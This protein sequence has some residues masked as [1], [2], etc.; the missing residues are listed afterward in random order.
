MMLYRVLQGGHISIGAKPADD[1]DC[2]VC[3]I[4]VMPER[5]TL[6]YIGNMYLYERNGDGAK[7]IAQGDTGM[8]VRSSIDDDERGIVTR[9][10]DLFDQL[11]FMVA[12]ETFALHAGFACGKH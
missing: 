9:R 4:G 10:L 11:A 8:R 5:F 7:G 1:S 3:Q 6:M 12:L 2:L